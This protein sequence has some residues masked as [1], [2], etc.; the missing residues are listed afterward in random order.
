MSFRGMIWKLSF[1]HINF[2]IPVIF[3]DRD[4]DGI[5]EYINLEFREIF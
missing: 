4:L 1:E 2:E 5:F 3:S